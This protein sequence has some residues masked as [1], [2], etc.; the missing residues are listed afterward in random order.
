[1]INKVKELELKLEN[2]KNKY[3]DFKIEG[4]KLVKNSLGKEESVIEYIKNTYSK[5]LIELQEEKE[6][7]EKECNDFMGEVEVEF[8]KKNF[9]IEI[10]KGDWLEFILDDKQ[11][12]IYK[13][14]KE[15]ELTNNLVDEM[16]ICI[17]IYA[18]YP[19]AVDEFLDRVLHW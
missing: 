15:N 18:R 10:K 12:S 11:Y 14:S 17:P 9:N 7:L 13:E 8:C 16:N 5:K 19:E 4:E 2:Y 3:N 6:V 1:M